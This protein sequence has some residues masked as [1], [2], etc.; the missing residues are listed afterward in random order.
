MPTD[1]EKRS[2]MLE[3]W[4]VAWKSKDGKKYFGSWRTDK[5]MVMDWV[6]ES[7]K[8]FPAIYHWCEQ[9]RL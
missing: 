2:P 3:Q 8:D 6:E 9:K 1:K 4:R 7:N 5:E